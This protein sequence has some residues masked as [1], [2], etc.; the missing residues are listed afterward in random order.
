MHHVHSSR[1]YRNDPY[2]RSRCRSLGRTACYYGW[3][4][5]RI[6]HSTIQAPRAHQMIFQPTIV[7]LI[8]MMK[9]LN[10][11]SFVIPSY[12]MKLPEQADGGNYR[13]EK[14]FR[15]LRS[16]LMNYN[17]SGDFTAGKADVHVGGIVLTQ[18]WIDRAYIYLTKAIH[19]KVKKKTEHS[20]MKNV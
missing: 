7:E 3:H 11:W 15:L 12:N 1:L 17:G 9:Y 4:I 20:T 14:V 19:I 16:G 18:P 10:I 6:Q 5:R 2:R 13:S 8:Q